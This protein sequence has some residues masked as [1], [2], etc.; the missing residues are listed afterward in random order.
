MIQ[1]P[2]D[3]PPRHISIRLEGWSRD[4]PETFK[5]SQTL[6]PVPSSGPSGGP[7]QKGTPLGC[8]KSGKT[9]LVLGRAQ[10][11]QE[12][13]GTRFTKGGETQ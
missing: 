13:E 3:N 4:M 1:K 8:N 2:T 12:P 7:P 10:P 11:L 9:S 6:T 5:D